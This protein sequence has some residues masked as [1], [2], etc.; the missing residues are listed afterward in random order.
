MKLNHR[1]KLNFNF[2]QG[3]GAETQISGS[4]SSS[5][6]Q[7]FSAPDPERFDPKLKTMVLFVQLACPTNYVLLNRNPNFK[8][9]LNHMKFFGSL[10]FQPS[11]I[12]WAPAPQ[13]WF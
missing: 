11:K 13:P 12:V 4:G 10:R 2:S 6:L 5:N 7:R 1:E 8:L 3:C 9:R